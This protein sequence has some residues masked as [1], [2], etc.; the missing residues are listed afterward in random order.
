MGQFKGRRLAPELERNFDPYPFLPRSLRSLAKQNPLG[1]P[2]QRYTIKVLERTWAA[3][4]KALLHELQTEQQGTNEIPMGAG[5]LISIP[6]DVSDSA[7]PNHSAESRKGSD[8]HGIHEL[9]I[10]EDALNAPLEGQDRDRSSSGDPAVQVAEVL[11][12]SAQ[13][14]E[15]STKAHTADGDEP[16]Q[17]PSRKRTSSTAGLPDTNDGGRVRSKRIRARESTAENA[18]TND[19]TATDASK[20]SDR[21]LE[22]YVERDER[23][24]ETVGEF[25]KRF[26]ADGLGSLR[27]LQEIAAGDGRQLSESGSMYEDNAGSLDTAVSDLSVA[28]RSWDSVKAQGFSHTQA[29]G[30]KG[31]KPKPAEALSSRKL[32]FMTL[33]EQ[34][35]TE[36]WKTASISY[37]PI[38]QGLGQFRTKINS[39]W[40]LITDAASS[41]LEHFLKSD[42]ED[43]HGPSSSL[44]LAVLKGSSYMRDAWPEDLKETI[45]QMLVILDAWIYPDLRKKSEEIILQFRS[46]GRPNYHPP[47]SGPTLQLMDMIETILELHMDLYSSM[48]NLN[49]EVEANACQVE[50]YRVDRWEMLMDEVMEVYP[51]IERLKASQDTLALRFIWQQHMFKILPE[52]IPREK[53]TETMLELK[54]WFLAFSGPAVKLQ[55]NAFMPEVSAKAAWETL[56][57]GAVFDLL[58]DIF[59][60]E[61]VDPVLVTDKLEIIL[62]PSAAG[63]IVDL[64]EENTAN[65]IASQH[66]NIAITINGTQVWLP[67][68]R[69]AAKFVKA[70]SVRLRLFL[71]DTLKDAW[72]ALGSPSEVFRCHLRI[73]GILMAELTAPSYLKQS[74]EN[75]Q[76]ILLAWLQ[77][78]NEHLI[79]ATTLAINDHSAFDIIDVDRLKLS[80]RSVASLA[81]LLHV[82][83]LF[84]DALRVGRIQVAESSNSL[85]KARRMLV[86]MQI[87]TWILLYTL[88]K[89]A[90]KQINEAFPAPS[91]DLAEYLHVVHQAT[92]LRKFCNASNKILLRVSKQEI[93]KTKTVENREMDTLQVLFDLYSLKIG[94]NSGSLEDH[95]CYGG[96]IDRPTAVMIVDFALS[97]FRR[98]SIKDLSKT[99]YRLAIER[100]NTF[101]YPFPKHP[102]ESDVLKFNVGVFKQFMKK[103]INP[104]DLYD[105]VKGF[106]GMPGKR[107]PAHYAK[108]ASKGW[109]FLMGQMALA[110]VR[111]QKLPSPKSKE[112]LETAE[113]Y[114]RADL[115]YN[116]EMWETWYRLAQTYDSMIEEDVLWTAEKLNYDRNRLNSLQRS[117]IRCYMTA[118]SYAVRQT[119]PSIETEEKMSELYT[120]FGMRMYA[121]SRPPFDMEVFSLK[122]YQRFFSGA[123]IY[124]GNPHLELTEF[125]AWKF[126]RVMFDKALV[127]KPSH[128]M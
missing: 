119:Q 14:M 56:Q 7:K 76:L 55:N 34:T 84:E 41:W 6:E 95:G 47:L 21:L 86:D 113:N 98:A 112:D 40:L 66:S 33:L 100:I 44:M 83:A 23:L 27:S 104:R 61:Q 107:V 126:A 69:L 91:E 127:H 46:V 123:G 74:R 89:E 70:Q 122:D 35:K 78:I 114:F 43:N 12:A 99:E 45:V 92:G 25:L 118:L 39:Q 93:F 4:G 51:E 102:S 62:D 37:G 20:D 81:R 88:L 13:G 101:V 75:R 73:I 64:P 90:T 77:V 11:E 79:K 80:A 2:P 53:V 16:T 63:L 117:A 72:E 42:F 115:Q 52:N 9:A 54:T 17:L 31:T 38:D 103:S 125:A 109:Y 1:A 97:I 68:F 94:P 50:K 106:W 58:T 32:E 30:N 48:K 128:W 26:E 28:L 5:I 19:K 59:R 82:S 108:V 110:R 3:V 49:S 87:R 124:Q 65:E 111:S 105:C 60:T 15:Q 36:N 29:V 67:D 22:T 57:R 121:S 120:D 96:E 116:P 8:A 71:W 10:E 24:F 18:T 85:L